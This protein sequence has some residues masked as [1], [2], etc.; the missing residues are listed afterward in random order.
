MSKSATA[1]TSPR[2]EPPQGSKKT[3]YLFRYNR[4][5]R[6]PHVH[7]P[8]GAIPH[9]L[10]GPHSACAKWMQTH[11]KGPPYYNSHLL[12]TA[13]DIEF[14][15]ATLHSRIRAHISRKFGYILINAVKSIRLDLT[16]QG[17]LNIPRVRSLRK[18]VAVGIQAFLSRNGMHAGH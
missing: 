18:S 5:I 10:T 17:L 14:R 2:A 4:E 9:F 16:A 8:A 7:L 13:Q 3:A 12:F 1:K 11:Q 15:K 6:R